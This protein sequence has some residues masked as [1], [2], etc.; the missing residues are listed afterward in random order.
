MLK[1][2]LILSEKMGDRRL[3]SIV[4]A[5][6]TFSS[7]ALPHIIQRGRLWLPDFNG[8]AYLIDLY[9]ERIQKTIDPH[10][11]S[12]NYAKTFAFAAT[13]DNIAFFSPGKE[14]SV[15]LTGNPLTEYTLKKQVF[16]ASYIDDVLYA[17]TSEKRILKFTGDDFEPASE[18]ICPYRQ[19]VAAGDRF[20][21]LTNNYFNAPGKLV[22][23]DKDSN[24]LREREIGENT[25]ALAYDHGFAY[26]GMHGSVEI[27]DISSLTS[28]G[29]MKYNV[30]NGV[31]IS[32]SVKGD[33]AVGIQETPNKK[34]HIL[35]FNSICSW[36]C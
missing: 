14:K 26:V 18:N 13:Q 34:M 4:P 31:L 22:V 29:D 5:G 1:N 10:E 27:Y 20:M 30:E 2:K 9:N 32:L 17:L 12:D 33:N 24:V 3:D 21:A 19:I 11:I 25:G 23:F 35:M 15:A 7:Y 8:P 36:S 16:S 6:M 28:I